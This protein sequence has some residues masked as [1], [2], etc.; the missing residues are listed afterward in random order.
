M[1][2]VLFSLALLAG[3]I[4]APNAVHAQDSKSVSL[5]LHNGSAVSIPLKIEKVMN[6]NL[7]PFSNSAVT[8]AEGTRIWYRK[9][10]KWV[11]FLVVTADLNGT[12]VEVDELL[13]KKG[14]K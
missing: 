6:P 14:L 4:V 9:E 13:K 10:N 7:S 12:V 11:D 3:V 2:S 1:R 5:T 8:V